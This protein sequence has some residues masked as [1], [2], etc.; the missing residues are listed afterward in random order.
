MYGTFIYIWLTFMV[1][2]GACTS[3]MDPMDPVILQTD[4]L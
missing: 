3:P 1:H 4:G 2:V